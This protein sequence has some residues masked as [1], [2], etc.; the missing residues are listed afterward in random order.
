MRGERR[1]ERAEKKGKVFFMARGEAQYLVESLSLNLARALSVGYPQGV[2]HN[3]GR[4]VFF[5]PVFLRWPQGITNFIMSQS[6]KMFFLHSAGVH[7]LCRRDEV[8]F[9]CDIICP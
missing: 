3:G 5:S 4:F 1:K 6:Q 7:C 8:S 9:F 2:I